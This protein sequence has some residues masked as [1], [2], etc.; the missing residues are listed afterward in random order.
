M[1]VPSPPDRYTT[2]A[3]FLI[4]IRQLRDN[5]RAYNVGPRPGARGGPLIAQW[6]EVG[7]RQALQCVEGHPPNRRAERSSSWAC[8]A[9]S[10]LQQQQQ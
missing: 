3:D 8:N 6:A 5:A 9:P 1:C 4:D 7:I 10:C 2:A